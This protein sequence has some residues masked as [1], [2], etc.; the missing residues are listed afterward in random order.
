MPKSKHELNAAGQDVNARIRCRLQVAKLKREVCSKLK[1]SA[2]G[3]YG[4]ISIP[5]KIKGQ[6]VLC[7]K[8]LCLPCRTRS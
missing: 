6:Q 4:A 2:N 7:W 3:K 5:M 1:E 8:R